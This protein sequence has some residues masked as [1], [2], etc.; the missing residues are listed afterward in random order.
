MKVL[1]TAFLLTA[2]TLVLLV[3]GDALGGA[4]GIKVALT[5]AVFMNAIAYF[6]SDKIAFGR[7]AQNRY[8]AKNCRGFIR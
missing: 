4:N 7:V 6:F 3:V 2:L 5:F 1:R 8:R